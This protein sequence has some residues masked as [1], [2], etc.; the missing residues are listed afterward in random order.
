MLLLF[1]G[2]SN[3]GREGEGVRE[4][5]GLNSFWG[6][7]ESLDDAY[8]KIKLMK[9]INFAHILKIEENK[10]EIFAEMCTHYIPRKPWGVKMWNFWRINGWDSQPL[11]I[12]EGGI[13]EYPYIRFD[14]ILEKK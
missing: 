14:S 5:A 8:D 4:I 7:V 11:E 9:D 6:V 12:F 1:V 13:G 10:I 2:N 3:T